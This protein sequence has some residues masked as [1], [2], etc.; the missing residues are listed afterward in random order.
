[1]ATFECWKCGKENEYEDDD[2]RRQIVVEMS[3]DSPGRA[4]RIIECKTCGEENEVG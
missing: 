4:R 1:M 3:A 2:A